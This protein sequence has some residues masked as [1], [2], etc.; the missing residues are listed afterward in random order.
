MRTIL[1]FAA[2]C[3]TFAAEG[4]ERR[5][6]LPDLLGNYELSTFENQ[7][8]A[9]PPNQRATHIQ[10]GIPISNFRGLRVELTG[11][12]LSGAAVGDGVFRQPVA[13]P[14]RGS[15][16]PSFSLGDFGLSW[17]FV[18]E[19]MDGRY[20]EVYEF[21]RSFDYPFAPDVVN[22][23]PLM[24]LTL[25]PSTF[26]FTN[27]NYIEVPTEPI[28]LPDTRGI[29]I[30]NPMLG[31]II[32]AYLVVQYIPEPASFVL[33]CIGAA[34]LGTRRPRRLIFDGASQRPPAD[35]RRGGWRGFDRPGR[36]RHD[37]FEFDVPGG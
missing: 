29:D 32:S 31:E 19:Q 30:T 16:A 35:R 33:L 26:S 7:P 5:I 24:T 18:A 21:P 23:D 28:T 8:A 12:I 37:G 9:D 10:T 11:S 27:I 17:L 4:A 13:T 6:P 14:L 22:F 36:M 34:A 20:S 3:V 1:V 15:F 25:S 2:A